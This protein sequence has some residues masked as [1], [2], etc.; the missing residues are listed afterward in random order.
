MPPT[1]RQTAG[2]AVPSVLLA[3][4]E[5]CGASL[6]DIMDDPRPATASEQA[7]RLRRAGGCRPSAAPAPFDPPDGPPPSRR[8]AKPRRPHIN[9]EISILTS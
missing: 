9:L 6:H 8:V 4:T 7:G 5:P 2:E 1:L 3:R